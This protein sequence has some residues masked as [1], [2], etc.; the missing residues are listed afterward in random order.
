[1]PALIE[2]SCAVSRSGRLG[3]DPGALGTLPRLLGQQAPGEVRRDVQHVGVQ[4]TDRSP[5]DA[6][7]R[8]VDPVAQDVED[9][10]HPGLAVGRQP[11]R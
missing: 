4:V 6:D 2:R 5:P 7:E 3:R 10:A 9:V 8:R 11:Q 1:M